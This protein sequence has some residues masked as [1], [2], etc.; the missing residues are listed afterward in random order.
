[1][2]FFRGWRIRDWLAYIWAA[3]M[4]VVASISI[5]PGWETAWNW[6]GDNSS[7][8]ASWV[9][10]FGSIGAIAAGFAVAGYQLVEQRREAAERAKDLVQRDL[11]RKLQL[12]SNR[13]VVS[14]AAFNRINAFSK[15]ASPQWQTMS[16]MAGD[17]KEIFNS[18]PSQ[19]VP[20]PAIGMLINVLYFRFDNMQYIF[21]MMAK[22]SDEAETGGHSASALKVISVCERQ[23]ISAKKIVKKQVDCFATAEDRLAMKE[24]GDATAEADRHKT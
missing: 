19:D 24:V 3:F 8:I 1:M 17:M 11:S 22:I 15:F 6:L 7:N 9:Q 4:V 2:D 23:I 5:Y 20:T 12:I 10:A 16:S 14:E 13:L 18:I 21:E